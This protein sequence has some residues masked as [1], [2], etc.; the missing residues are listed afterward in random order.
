MHNSRKTYV[1]PSTKFE[2]VIVRSDLFIPLTT[3]VVNPELT[4]KTYIVKMKNK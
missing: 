4:A 1:I 2:G 3:S